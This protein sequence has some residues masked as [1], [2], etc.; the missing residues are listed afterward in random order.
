MWRTGILLC[1]CLV[2]GARA[3]L[4]TELARAQKKNDLAA[5]QQ[6][7]KA[8]RTK[9]AAADKRAVWARIMATL[10]P[11]RGGAFVSAHLLAERLVYACVEQHDTG[12]L[13]AATAALAARANAKDSGKHVA[14]VHALAIAVAAQG[15]GAAEVCEQAGRQSWPE[16]AGMASIAAFQGAKGDA[17]RAEE[18][19]VAAML[20]AK[21]SALA[22]A[23]AQPIKA[24][25]TTN[26][27]AVSAVTRVMREIGAI[28]VQPLGSPSVGGSGTTALGKRWRKLG[29][30]KPIVVLKRTKVLQLSQ[31]FEKFEVELAARDGVKL[32]AHGGVVLAL[33]RWGAGVRLLDRSGQG[34]AGDESEVPGP[35]ELIHRLAPG[36][37]WTL[38][39]SGVRIR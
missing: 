38:T 33:N 39:K 12:H 20:A 7:W 2:S 6:L 8:V 14:L 3:D 11:K 24:R 26:T 1:T 37:T 18:A 19:V 17:K 28:T 15:A 27:H 30:R 22:M 25:L 4:A 31:P 10:D 5:E 34:Q 35:F 9:H 23:W 16:L 13:E 32:H 29:K 21:D 36:E